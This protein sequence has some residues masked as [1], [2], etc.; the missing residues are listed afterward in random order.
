[1][2]QRFGAFV[3]LAGLALGGAACSQRLPLEEAGATAESSGYAAE[4][5]PLDLRQFEVVASGG[6]YRGVFL[7]L[8]RFPDS[9]AAAHY[10][11]PARIVLDIRGPTGAESAEERFPGNDNIVSAVRVSRDIG[12]LRVILDIAGDHTPE[13]TVHRMADWIMIRMRPPGS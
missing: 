7:K 13:Y 4:G 2:R 1:M 12:L 3:L 8:S 6:G 10:D 9:V 11:D 5:A